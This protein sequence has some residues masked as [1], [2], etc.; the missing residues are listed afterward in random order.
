MYNAHERKSFFR[1]A[2]VILMVIILVTFFMIIFLR[3][4]AADQLSAGVRDLV[5]TKT[6]AGHI[7]KAVQLLYS[8]DNDFRFYTLTYD[9]A[10]LH[11]Y[12]ASLEA[13]SAHIDTAIGTVS[14][15]QQVHRLL[16][17]KEEKTQLFLHTRLYV[18]SLLQLSQQWDTT[19]APPVIQELKKIKLPRREQID[20]IISSTSAAAQPKKKLFG[21]IKDAISNKSRAHEKNQEVKVIKRAADDTREQV[22]VLNDEALKKLQ[23]TYQQFMRDAAQS[24]AN[25]NR[26]EYA[27]VMAN[28]RLFNVLQQVLANLRQNMVAE[29]DKKRWLLSQDIG[30]SLYRMDKH[31]YWEIPLLLLLSAIIIYGIIRLYKYDLDLLRSKQQAEKYARQKSEFVTTMSHE[32]R[33]PIHSV[34]GYTSQLEREQPGETA[35]AI[36][37][38]AEMLLSVV[39][40][41][42][43]YTQ[44]EGG[45]PLLKQEKF[46]PRTAIEEI[47]TSLQVQA[48]IKSLQLQS[49]IFFPTSQQV[50]GDVFRLKQVLMN[51]IANAIKYTSKGEVTVTAHL[52]DGELLQVSVKDTGAGIPPNEL[53]KIFD[54]FTQGRNGISKGS[55]LGLHIAK[56]I[57]DLHDGKIDVKST[58]GKGSTFYFEIRYPAV[59]QTPGTVKITMPVNTPSQTTAPPANVRLL[60]VEDSVLNQKLLALLLDRLQVSYSITG[61]AEEALEIYARESFD[62]ILTDIDLPGMDGI[63]F[64]QKIRQLPD[65]QKAAITIIAIT[66]NVMDEDIS[67]YMNCGL[68]DYIMK[69]YREEDILEKI[70]AH[71]LTVI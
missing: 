2:V 10:Y 38:S 15:Q 37:N 69:P 55:G 39:N 54:A 31:T 70:S 8:A 66:G 58:P 50:Y 18:D 11:S 7:D 14:K 46:S 21:R 49:N 57:I 24:H 28:Q 61:T 60:V 35:S 64:T 52:R 9:P 30:H 59:V 42:L 63:A 5:A 27:L 12:V 68:N 53:P 62:M 47:C 20:T 48:G 65:K 33:T 19:A 13:V 56:K 34:L 23:H 51:L 16:S 71:G 4:R 45:R 6:D 17:D 41:V 36:R 44:M 25:M 32:I 3:K 40:N 26:K 22:S 43:D 67:L 1:F 29:T